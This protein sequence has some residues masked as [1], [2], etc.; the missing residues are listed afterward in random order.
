MNR[1]GSTVHIP[2]GSRV[3]GASWSQIQGAGAYFN[4]IFN[5]R[6][7]VQVGE[8]GDRG[9]M[10][11]VE[12][13]FTVQGGTAGAVVLEWNVHESETGSGKQLFFPFSFNIYCSSSFQLLC[14]TAS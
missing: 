1:V 2:T 7:V 5:P 9:T 11:I 10:E 12:M 4:D 14:M 13:M 8:K 6:V 3:Q